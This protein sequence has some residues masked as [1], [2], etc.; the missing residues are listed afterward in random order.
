MVAHRIAAIVTLSASIGLFAMGLL[1]CAK[2]Q[3]TECDGI[4]CPQ[5]RA[6]V[7]GGMCVDEV[8]VSACARV[9]EGMPCSL[10]E[11][12]VGTCQQSLCLVGTCGDGVINAIDAC[13]GNDLGGKTCMDFGSPY[14]EGL[15]CAADCSFDTSGCNGFC[16]DNVKQS[17]E[18]C[19][20]EDFGGASCVT[21]GFQM[22]DLVCTSDCQINS[23]GCTG[24]CGDGIKNGFEPCDGMDFGGSTCALRG[25]LG[26]VQPLTCTAKCSFDPVSC[27]CGG[28]LCTPTKQTCVL[29]DGIYTCEAVKKP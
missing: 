25:Y 22:G 15:K 5:G 21:L 14:P 26:A 24:K 13:D 27:T 12:G 28:Q 4:V 10:P 9:A 6:C 18:Q 16:G 20:S 8:L 3:S 17:N 2:S 23:S 11:I 7:K 19:D 29:Q 1:G